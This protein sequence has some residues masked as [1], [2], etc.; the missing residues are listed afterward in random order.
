VRGAWRSALALSGLGAIGYLTAL[1]LDGPALVAAWAA[2]AVALAQLGRDGRDELAR[3]AGLALLGLACVHVLVFDA[4]PSALL[5]GSDRLGAAALAL[6]TAAL[7][8]ARCGIIA[9]DHPRL[10]DA[11][12]GAAGA[13]A[14]YLASIAV[15]TAFAHS[16]ATIVDADLGLTVRQQGQVMLSVFWSAAGLAT[17]IAGLRLRMPA[18]RTAALALLLA[19]AAK[20][21]LYDLSNLTS[22]YRVISVIVLGLLLLAG[23]AAHQRLRPVTR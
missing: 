21:F 10:R 8:A 11:L 2:E 15:V 5:T 22:I 1:T 4:P 14:L 12:L 6:A 20:V 3:C 7:A 13:A 9:T 16:T 23:A 19:T 18:L 17:L